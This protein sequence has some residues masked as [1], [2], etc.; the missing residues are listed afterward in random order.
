M[1]ARLT[2]RDTVYLRVD[3]ISINWYCSALLL[4][5]RNGDTFETLENLKGYKHEILD[6]AKVYTYD[7]HPGSTT[8]FRS[9]LPQVLT[10]FSHLQF[11]DYARQPYSL[12]SDPRCTWVLEYAPYKD[13]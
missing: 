8:T 7:I 5:G 1:G 12:C 10:N 6:T 9:I 3:F 11:Q 2:L 13:Q 4:R